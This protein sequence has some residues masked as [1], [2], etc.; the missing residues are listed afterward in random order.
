MTKAETLAKEKENQ[1]DDF[2]KD[3]SINKYKLDEECLSH[4]SRYAYYAEAQAVAKGDVSAAKDKLELVESEVNLKIRKKFADEGQKVTESIVASA[5]AMDEDVI[6]AKGKL[7]EAELIYSRLSVA[8]AAMETRR[9]ELDN[10]VKLYCAGYFS[11]PSAGGVKGGI[12]AMTE[13]SIRKQLN[14]KE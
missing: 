5:L 10:L 12:N 11:T 1:T 3:L 6:A 7:R 9:S 4:S 8:V 13:N 14:E 2:Q